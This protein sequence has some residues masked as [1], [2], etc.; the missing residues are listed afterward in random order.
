[1]FL[2]DGS[3]MLPSALETSIGGL[4]NGGSVRIQTIET[5]LVFHDQLPSLRYCFCIV[6]WA[7]CIPVL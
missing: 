6:R 2:V 3:V 1:M 4:A 5:Q 7:S